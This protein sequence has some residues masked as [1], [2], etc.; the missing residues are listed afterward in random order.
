MMPIQYRKFERFGG[1]RAIVVGGSMA[2]LV[3]ARVLSDHFEEVLVVERDAIPDDLLTAR[4][5]VPQG[6][7]LHALL[8]R[9]EKILSDL[10]P[11]IVSALEADGAVR[12]NFGTE[13]AWHHAGG[14]KVR[15]DA[16]IDF[17][18][19]SRPLLE[20]H[21]RR[22]VF[23]RK[24]IR[25][26]DQHDVIGLLVSEDRTR[27]NGVRIQRRDGT[28]VAADERADLIVDASGRGSKM[29]TWLEEIGY[30]RP[31]ETTVKVRVGYA[32]RVYRMPDPWP[33]PWKI[34]YILASA[35]ES[36]RSGA[37][38]PM[39]NGRF[40]VGLCG[41]FDDHPEDDEQRFL[42]FAQ[43]L[44]NDTLYRVLSRSEPLSDIQTHKFPAHLRRHYEHSTRIPEGLA[45]IGDAFASFNPIFG[46]GMTT[47]CIDALVLDDS[48][49]EQR[50]HKGSAV[51]DGFTRRYH[52]A[53][54]KATELPWL[55]STGEDFRYPEVE[56]KRPPLYAA[57][58]W[59]TGLV[60]QAA[61][62]DPIVYA[63]F[64]RAMHML[65]GVEE[66]TDPRIVLR[67]LRASMSRD[68]RRGAFPFVNASQAT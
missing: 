48:L 51:M 24:G 27:I 36:R 37:I 21:V 49:S 53:I 23:E 41:L 14:W 46:Q 3:A 57:M 40:I 16:D 50:M 47:A 38:F 4:K 19:S 22:R 33:Y 62:S 56:G 39:E 60:H 18:C 9:G 29:G 65:G 5:G 12:V 52:S 32:G 58:K 55:M 31:D 28:D 61:L 17:I 59:Y 67:V 34:L 54:A 63:R 10:F 25:R 8:A 6:R 43:G 35:P 20:A 7:Q 13:G 45:V 2:G 15:T 1:R 30:S 42:A 66:L 44:P 11:G 68:P 26:I 64:L